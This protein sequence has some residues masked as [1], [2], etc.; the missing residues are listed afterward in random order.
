MIMEQ[1]RRRRHPLL[2]LTV[3]GL[4]GL[5]LLLLLNFFT[6]NESSEEWIYTLEWINIL[7]LPILIGLAFAA[8]GWLFS[9]LLRSRYGRMVWVWCAAI[10]AIMFAIPFFMPNYLFIPWQAQ[11]FLSLCWASALLSGALCLFG[12]APKRSSFAASL[13]C[14]AGSVGLGLGAL[15]LALLFTSQNADY[16]EFKNSESRHASTEKGVPEDKGW[17]PWQ[18]GNRPAAPGN[19]LPAFQRMT[20]K[21]HEIYDVKYTFNSKGWRI[22]PEADPDAEND[23]LLFGCSFTFGTGLE[24]EQT[25]AWR[26]ASLLGSKWQVDNYASGGSS[27]NQ[28]LCMLEHNLVEKPTGRRRYALYLA[29]EHHLLRNDYFPWM[30]HY[31]LN[32][33][34][35]PA[36]GGKPRYRLL[37]RLPET[38][39]GSQL[40]R[41]IRSIAMANLMK[42]ADAGVD[43]YLGMIKKCANILESEYQTKLIVLLWPDIEYIKDRLEEMGITAILARTMLTEWNTPEDYGYKY[44]IDRRYENHP[45]QLA[46]SQ[47]ASGLARYFKQLAG[48]SQ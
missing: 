18:C 29:I 5:G 39:N 6:G 37:Y 48:T 38:F 22:T 10:C 1:A 9:R 13:L 41:E 11:Y 45:N 26:L 32:A 16:M 36:A 3:A 40:A 33:A 42:H 12:I 47:L 24:D 2:Y 31:E 17:V 46:T 30:P 44:R 25:W 27:I 23:L 8:G 21:G 19:P 43:L 35:E 20:R 15:E 28:A 7:A 4:I 14:L 34:G